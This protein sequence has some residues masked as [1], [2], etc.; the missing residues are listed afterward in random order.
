[1]VKQLVI[2]LTQQYVSTTNETLQTREAN[3]ELRD[4][5]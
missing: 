4:Q 1:L 2:L 5:N 3:C